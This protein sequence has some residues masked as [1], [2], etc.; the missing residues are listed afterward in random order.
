M[1][2]RFLVST[3]SLGMIAS[4]ASA[5]TS[6]SP[7]GET[8][9]DEIIVYG[10]REE[11]YRATVAPQTNKS[12]TSLK[13][14]PFSVQ[15]VTRELIDDRGI[16]TL[17]EA[18]RYVPGLSPQI[19]FGASNER[20]TIRG[21][22][23]PFNYKNGFRRSGFTVDDQL[24]NIEQIE[25]LK[26]P[27]SALYGRAETGGIINIVTK[28]PRDT[29]FA[30]V[31]AEYGS[32]DALRLT[33]DVNAPLSSTVAARINLS[34]DDRESFRD[35]VFSKDFFV[36]PVVSWRP[37][38]ATTLTIEGEFSDRNSYFDRGFGNNPIFL[39]APRER[40]FGNTDARLDRQAGLVSA[41]L[42][43]RFS[44]AISARVAASYSEGTINGLFYA[45]AFPPVLGATGPN[46]LV[47]V[48]PTDSFDNQRN[49]TAQAELYARFATGPLQH[50]AL[51][52]IER[53]TD[54]WRYLFLGGAF[55]SLP[56]DNPV[57]SGPA[58][59]PFVPTIDGFSDAEAT[60]VYAQDEISIGT[61]RLLVGA[62][63]DWNEV[64]A[65][66]RTFGQTDP[67]VRSQQ[68]LSPRAGLTWTPSDAVSLYA[69][70]SRSFLPQNF[71][72][73]R[74]G[75]L[76]T[77][78]TGEAFEAGA[79]FSLLNGRIRPTISL[80]DIERAGAAVSDPD[81]FNFVVQLG[82]SRT[83]G[84]EI[85]VPAAITP[86]WRLI[87]S[88]THLDAQ[89]TADTSIPV[90]TSL[91]NAPDHSASLWTSYDVPGALDGLSIGFGA[92][93][94]GERV[95]N[96]NGSI[97]L[98]SYTRVD[99]NLSYRFDLG[100]N[101]LKLQLN[102][103]NLFDKFYYDS[104][105]AFLPLYPGAPRTVTVRLSYRFGRAT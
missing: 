50:K 51:V 21:F 48:R 105:G 102:V 23:Q 54:K 47:R 16:A 5:Q 37:S 93:H 55:V 97:L 63:Y 40:Q 90:G 9:A 96:N 22:T 61:L 15:V 83:R 41:F 88:Y 82:R 45:Y 11:G 64:A 33:A 101:P 92:I 76:P 27:A 35:L 31:T 1:K 53:G 86:R 62:R 39:R 87:A 71:G 52:G 2:H 70:W 68:K 42:D 18:L 65:L 67:D 56:F 46:P 28:R 60:A 6:A 94:I 13:E 98:P 73:L 4:A 69:S 8:P 77:A 81:D 66:D 25:I 104:G 49:V 100:G 32:F 29:A 89:I 26:G 84:I 24:A 17:G 78:L 85:D 3:L 36:A 103:L 80:F 79:K 75:G 59:G 72:V 34:Y 14:M 20:F 91:V 38:D 19:G 7:P 44:E 30:Q 43:H 99:S 10:T 57:Y 95:A 74:T 58:Q 12:D